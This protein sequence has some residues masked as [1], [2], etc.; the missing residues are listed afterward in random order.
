MSDHG[1][2]ETCRSESRTYVREDLLVCRSEV[3]DMKQK[4]LVGGTGLPDE[5]R[6][7]LCFLLVISIY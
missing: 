5:E 4:A 3:K 7:L 2:P 6:V 1:V